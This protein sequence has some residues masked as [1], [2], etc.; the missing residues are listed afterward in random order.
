MSANADRLYDLVPVVY[1]MRDAEHG[2]KLRALLQVIA[3]Q[4]E[5]VEEDIAQLYENWF[6]ETCQDW[7]VPY[8]GELVGYR[9]VHTAGQP[10]TTAAAEARNEI[11]IPRREVANTIRFRRR[12]GTLSIVDDLALAVSGWPVHAVE[13]YRLL[14]VMQHINHL[15]LDRGRTVELRNRDALDHLGG[16]FDTTAHNVDVRRVNSQH[17]AGRSNIPELGVFAWRLKTYT[18]T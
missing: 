11:M 5:L 12:K 3:E 15:R 14:A 9:P 1:R 7:V 17:V 8:I 18:V 13:F 16:A 10:G 4:V 2:Y 6:I